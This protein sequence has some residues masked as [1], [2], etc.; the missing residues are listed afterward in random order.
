MYIAILN[1]NFILMLFSYVDKKINQHITLSFLDIYL[2][3]LNGAIFWLQHRS[4]QGSA[5]ARDLELNFFRYAMVDIGLK[6]SPRSSLKIRSP[7]EA[8]GWTT[9]TATIHDPIS[10]RRE[11]ASQK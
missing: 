4:F 7:A 11:K 10:R 9:S 8:T 1:F 5:F 6:L 3:Y 2:R